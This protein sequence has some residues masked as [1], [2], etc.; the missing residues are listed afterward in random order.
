MKLAFLFSLAAV[1]YADGIVIKEMFGVLQRKLNFHRGSAGDG[2]LEHP[3]CGDAA[4]AGINLREVRDHT[5]NHPPFR[6]RF[7][8]DTSRD[9]RELRPN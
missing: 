7:H 1:A 5:G 4:G 6:R 8:K 2:G 3:P 9:P